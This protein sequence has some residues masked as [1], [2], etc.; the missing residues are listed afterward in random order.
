MQDN[1]ALRVTRL[2]LLIGVLVDVSSSM[3][4]QIGNSGQLKETRL[5]DVQL[6]RLLPEAKHPT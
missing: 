6:T 1:S 3:R 4:E 5:E 2:P